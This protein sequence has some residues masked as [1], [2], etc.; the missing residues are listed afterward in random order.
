MC[1]GKVSGTRVFLFTLGAGVLSELPE[2]PG[3]NHRVLWSPDG[4]RLLFTATELT[5][6]GS[7]IL[8]DIVSVSDRSQ[9]GYTDTLNLSSSN[10][11]F[12][13]NIYW[14]ANH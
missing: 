6:T 1:D 12:I 8:L 11:L 9:T 7:R 2:M 5:D 3:L 14:L 4:S 13:T 10:Y